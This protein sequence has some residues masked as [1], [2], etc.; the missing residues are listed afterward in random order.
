MEY[1]FSVPF[2]PTSVNKMYAYNFHTKT[3]YL[4]KD[5]SHFKTAIKISCPAMKFESDPPILDVHIE[6]HS[7]KWRCKNGNFRK[8][9][10]MNLDK[11]IYDAISE[12]IGYDDSL[13]FYWSG[14]KVLSDREYTVVCVKEVASPLALHVPLSS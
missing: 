6:Y 10:G 13:V 11:L 5:A 4:T 9:D 2:L 1:R 12:R 3:K 14:Q 7:P 8:A